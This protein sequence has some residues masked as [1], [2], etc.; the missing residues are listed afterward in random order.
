MSLNPL[1]RSLLNGGLVVSAL[2]VG[3]WL[4]QGF[5]DKPLMSPSPQSHAV[6]FKTLPELSP[7]A[8]ISVNEALARPLFRPSRRPSEVALKQEQ[9]SR[10][11]VRLM[12][13]LALPGKQLALM[14]GADG[15]KLQRLSLGDAIEGWQ[16]IA[17][18]ERSV[19]LRQKD[20]ETRVRLHEA[21]LENTAR[22]GVATGESADPSHRSPQRP[23]PAKRRT[24]TFP[25]AD[26]SMVLGMNR[27]ESGR[28]ERP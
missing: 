20:R 27:P 24:R 28:G 5:P 18:A 7:E 2:V 10:P 21:R 15:G 16:L 13:I 23:A 19:I 9:E 11:A 3:G 25:A 17:V 14:T 4:L 12:G 8:R 1:G 6:T 22:Q 26:L